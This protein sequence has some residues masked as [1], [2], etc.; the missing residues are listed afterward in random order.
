[1]TRSAPLALSAVAAAAAAF[2]AGPA[3]AHHAFNMYD[4][5]RYETVTGTVKTWTWKNPHAM[6]DFV[7]A[8][9]DG[10]MV[11]W[12]VECSSPNII[13]RKGWSQ[14]SLK[15]GDRM[16][17]TLHPMKDGSLYGLMVKTTTPRGETLK[18]KD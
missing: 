10:K 6:I 17:I 3:S 13:G 14:D 8:N 15:V 9:P 1:M 7:V 4:N 16:S 2:A 5:A 12:S 11:T 18:D